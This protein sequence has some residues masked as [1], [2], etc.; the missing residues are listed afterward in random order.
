MSDIVFL[1]R[2]YNEGVKT[3]AGWLR[4]S[5]IDPS[6]ETC[7]SMECSFSESV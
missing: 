5:I 1:L 4:I 2:T 7:L 6:T 3:K